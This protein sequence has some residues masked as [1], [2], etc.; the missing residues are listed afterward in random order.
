VR[1][2]GGGYFETLGT[3]L[4]A[5]RELVA[6]DVDDEVVK[7]L[8][9]EVLAERTW[10]GQS[11]VRKRVYVKVAMPGIWFEVAGVVGH[12]RQDGLTGPSRETIYLPAGYRGAQPSRWTVRTAG[13]P[14]AMAAGVRAAVARVDERILVENLEPLGARVDRAR[15][16]TRFVSTLVGAF[17][18]LALALALV[19][20]YGVVTYM[21]RERRGEFGLRMALGA[22]RSGIL[23]LVLGKGLVLSALGIAGGLA[24]TFGL[25]RVIA[26]FVVGVAPTDPLTLAGVAALFVAMAVVASLVPAVRAL[27]VDPAVTLREE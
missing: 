12:Q 16:P 20:L 11:A 13:E 7:V 24:G 9:D 21:V 26:G 8:V 27:R 1:I 17:G 4:L 2:V 19:G 25:T 18:L 15:A 10:P 6:A 23:R 5:G 22:E 14:A 3:P